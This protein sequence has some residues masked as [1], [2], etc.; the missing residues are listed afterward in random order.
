MNMIQISAISL[1]SVHHPLARY[2]SVGWVGYNS[3]KLDLGKTYFL[4]QV[5]FQNS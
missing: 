1:S 4:N 2:F 5:N 3:N